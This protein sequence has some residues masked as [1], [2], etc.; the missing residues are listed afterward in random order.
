MRIGILQ[1]GYLPWLG[2]FEQIYRSDV[3]VIY[4]DVQYDKHGWRNRNRIKASNGIQWLTVPVIV[5][6]ENDSLIKDV[7]IDN[8]KNWRRKHLLSIKQNYSAARFFKEYL[9]LFEEAYSKEWEY[10]VDIDVYFISKICEI[11]GMAD[12]KIV[13]SSDLNIT[14]GRIERLINICKLF[15]ADT[16]YEG[17]S[18]RN[19]INEAD[20]AVHGIKVEFQDYR[21]PVYKQLYGEFVP[22]LSIID[23]I[24][25]HG[26]KSL[27]VLADINA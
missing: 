21:H 26:N 19:Y 22:Y 16:F 4:D 25:N 11:L 13:R 7:R 20:F 15:N 14:G 27:F 6:N 23:L 2:F 5:S 17:A 24:F 10:L 9:P 3:F 12:K 1:P 8:K 18:G